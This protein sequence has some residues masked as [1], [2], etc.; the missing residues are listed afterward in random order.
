MKKYFSSVIC[1]RGYT[2][3][4]NTIYKK[5]PSSQ[6]FI[7]YGGDDFERAV[8]FSQMIKNFKGYSLSVFNPFYDESAD[9]I[10]IEN[11]NT[12]IIS[13]GGFSH[14]S[15]VLAGIWEKYYPAVN[16]KNYPLDLCREILVLKAKENNCY[17]KACG[18]LKNASYVKEKIHAEF[19]PYLNDE[20]IINY[21]RRFCGRSLKSNISKGTG[22]IRLLSSA[23]PLG[24][25]THYDTIFEN[26]ETIISIDDDYGFAGSVILG[27]IK[28]F[29]ISEK[30]PFIMNPTYFANDIPQTLIFPN[31]S[32]SITVCDENHQLPFEPQEKVTVSRFMTSDSILNSKKLETLKSIENKLLEDCVLNIYEGR[33]Y[34]F[35]YNDLVKGYSDIN[36]AKKNADK[37]CERLII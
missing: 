27:I 6:V 19:S 4:Y 13:D 2:S 26:C 24:I 8:F 32:L 7:I 36:E 35:K 21:V 23:T 20:K 33:D 28:D 31:Q 12:Y 9:G 37:L 30:I 1:S 34:R 14:I 16:E 5:H 22:T 29:A 18:I 17:K 3:A 15:P 11:L 25:H 10:Y